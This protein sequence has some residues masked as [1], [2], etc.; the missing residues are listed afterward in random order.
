MLN[1]LKTTAGLL[2]GT[3][4]EDRLLVSLLKKPMMDSCESAFA[5]VV[6]E[7]DDANQVVTL[8]TDHVVSV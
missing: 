2:E 5:V 4:L 7:A 3:F 6:V 8:L 1:A